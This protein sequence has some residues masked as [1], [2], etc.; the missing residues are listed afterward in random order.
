MIIIICCLFY[1]VIV[2]LYEGEIEHNMVSIFEG[3]IQEHVCDYNRA[4]VPGTVWSMER[5]ASSIC[6]LRLL[7]Q[8]NVKERTRRTVKT[9]NRGSCFTAGTELCSN[10]FG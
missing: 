8:I 3:G 7:L 10:M 5:I 6:S 2:P 4:M 9:L 1:I